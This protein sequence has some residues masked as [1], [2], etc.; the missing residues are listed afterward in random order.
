VNARFRADRL[1][2]ISAL[3]IAALAAACGGGGST[4]T[5]PPPVGGFSNANLKG[6][7]AFSMSGQNGT[8]G[9]FFARIGS[10][11]ADGNGNI[12]GGIEDVNVTGA[13]ETID[14]TAST[15]SIQHDGRGIIN[16]I[17]QKGQLSFS[18]TLISPTRGLLAE[19][20]LTATA[21]GSFILQDSA[22][23]SA[24]S[25]N[26]NY[27][28]D[29]SGLD[30]A[31]AP[32]SIVGQFQ[33][34]GSGALSGVLDE[35]DNAVHS[36]GGKGTPLT[37]GSYQIDATNGPTSGRGLA[38]F[39]ANGISF[40]YAF[41]IVNGSK[42]RFM[43][44][45]STGSLTVGDA[46]IQ[47]NVPTTNAT[48]NGSFVFLL[49]GS[50][51][52]G[53]ITR[54]G[55]FT[56]DGNGGLKSIFADTND[57]GTVA[58]VPKGNL[59]NADYTIDGNFPGS[60]RGTLTFTDSSLGQFQFVFYLSSA[61]DGVIQDVSK[62]NVADGMIQLQT[63]A[64][65]SPSSFAGD[66]AL[67][68]TGVSNNGSTQVTAEEDY[69]GQVN[70]ASSSSGGNVTGTVDFSEF[71]SNQ[72]AF[73]NVLVSGNGL[74]I[75]GDGST[76]TGTRNTLQLKLSTTPTSTINFV[77]YIIDSQHMVVAGTDSN[78]VISGVITQQAP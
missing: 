77:P 49:S 41:Y 13:N 62:N 20:D 7:Y 3:S 21:S 26:G 40:N 15:Y 48:F 44:N 54:I 52:T 31:G 5:P 39:V 35:N 50:G 22:T 78:R 64:P 68:F 38:T 23:F 66:H 55:R 30:P 2:L 59:S 6:Q 57:S 27:V 18:V 51:S 17:N 32:D 75:G 8:T 14:F 73:F 29:F 60:G 37:S 76:S 24:G 61:S 53:P 12:T 16:L 33:A 56:A 65:F 46:S 36:N 34:N 47:S 25:F 45:S 42:V 58:K 63:G 10:F 71:S 19:T 69:V 67:N 1:G 72:G 28:F 9:A 4:P 70:F 43:E 11:T 74:S